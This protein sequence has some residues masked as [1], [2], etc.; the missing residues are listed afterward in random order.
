MTGPHG[1]PGES[2]EPGPKGWLLYYPATN[3]HFYEL[4]LDLF[5]KFIYTV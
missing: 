5:I 4:S 1:D 3:L 2:G